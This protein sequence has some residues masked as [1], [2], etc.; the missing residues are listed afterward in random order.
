[1]RVQ[2]V[3][4]IRLIAPR[5]FACCSSLEHI[6]IVL[7]RPQITALAV[8]GAPGWCTIGQMGWSWGRVLRIIRSLW[9]AAAGMR[10]ASTSRVFVATIRD[11]NI[12]IMAEAPRWILRSTASAMDISGGTIPLR[13]FNWLLAIFVSLDQISQVP[14]R[15][16][17][18]SMCKLIDSAF[19]LDVRNQ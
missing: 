3:N 14:C 2:G 6:I 18:S 7:R 19:S 15:M 17:A 8:V 10:A 13:R 12:I 4:G 9:L 5:L 16:T 1:M 11:V